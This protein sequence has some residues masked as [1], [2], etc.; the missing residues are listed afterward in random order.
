MVSRRTFLSFAGAFA[1]NA[2]LPA[3]ADGLRTIGGGAFGSYWRSTA[4]APD[5]ALADLEQVVATTDALFS[6]YRPDSLL[7]RLNTS[8]DT[9]WMPLPPP[10]RPVFAAALAIAEQTDGAFDPTVGPAVARHGFGPINDAA[11]GHH[12]Q[13]ALRHDALRK[14]HPRLSLDLCGIAKGWALDQMTDRLIARGITDFV[15]DLGGEV[16]SHGR[17]PSG[18][19][20]QVAVEAPGGIGPILSP[21]GMAVA[22]SGI[23][24]QSYSSGGRVIGHIIDPRRDAPALGD[25]LSVSVLD[26]SAMRADALATALMARPHEDAIRM[27][28]AMDIPALFQLRDTPHPRI[29]TTGSFA[30]HLLT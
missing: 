15:L 30:G 11:K 27:A 14:A 12:G 2:A 8:A 22:T 1:A 24:V 6:P 21:R 26:R 7:T 13:V 18:R 17:H 25:T 10:A 28:E 5:A 3:W 23:T 29:F 9:D 20:W 19:D 16:R 4:R